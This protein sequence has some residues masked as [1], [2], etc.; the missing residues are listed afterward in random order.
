MN[1]SPLAGL[2]WSDLFSGVWLVLGTFPFISH[3]RGYLQVPIP[4]HEVYEKRTRLALWMPSLWILVVWLFAKNTKTQTQKRSSPDQVSNQHI[5]GKA[6]L[7]VLYN[8]VHQALS[9]KQQSLI[10]VCQ[11]GFIQDTQIDA[12]SLFRNNTPAKRFIRVCLR[13]K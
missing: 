2:A 10:S 4:K 7:G 9:N 3:F 11:T 13:I 5:P 8:H 1:I 6:L 12:N